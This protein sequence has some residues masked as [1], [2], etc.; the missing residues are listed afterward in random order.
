MPASAGAV[1]LA[2]AGAVLAFAPAARAQ[3]LVQLRWSAPAECPT[4]AAVAAEVS[5]L[6]AQAADAP[7]V[8]AAA[9]V[10][11]AGAL[12]RLRVELAHHAAREVTSASCLTVAHAAALMV[13]IAVDPEAARFAPPVDQPMRE[14]TAPV[15]PAGGGL[16]G[17]GPAGTAPG[18]ATA[19]SVP[20]GPGVVAPPGPAAPSPTAP[21]AAPTGAAGARAGSRRVARS[22]LP[23]GLPAST[24]RPAGA[25][26]VRAIDAAAD[27]PSPA[28]AAAPPRRRWHLFASGTA[29]TAT[30]GEVAASA[31]VGGGVTFGPLRFDVAAAFWPRRAVDAA[32]PSASGAT[33][34]GDVDLVT[35]ALGA[36]YAPP[37]LARLVGPRFEIDL[38]C[39]AVEL[40]RMHAA[41]YGV[42]DPGEASRLWSGARAGLAGAL[43][44][45]PWLAMRL[46]LEAVLPLNS[47]SFEVG[48]VG[49]V[50]EPSFS[51]RATL[52]IEARP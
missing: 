6:L 33:T 38:P 15:A 19:G 52:S 5:A 20:A 45:S 25:S 50:H 21:R 11:R 49:T 30:L 24:S 37:P 23:P 48:H 12:Y 8:S 34:G 42:S 1:G 40:G 35:G 13:A 43:V 4:Q 14:P 18:A 47:P 51:G 39:V 32:K 36:C 3:P 9:T 29:D 26:E 46:R 16:P 28:A 41:A 31:E 27:E 22:V 17:A 10:T 7:K 2:V 44:A